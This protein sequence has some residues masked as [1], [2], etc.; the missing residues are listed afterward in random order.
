MC[1]VVGIVTSVGGRVSVGG[2]VLGAACDV[3]A[4]RGPDGAGVWREGHVALG[5]RRLAVVDLSDAGAQP[6]VLRGGGGGADGLARL[7]IAYNGEVYND[8]EIR[9][10]LRAGMESAGER[11]V[12]GCDTETLG[13]AVL[14][15]GAGA[16][17]RVRGMYAFAAYDPSREVLTLA[18][19]PVGIKPLYWARWRVAGRDE[20]GFASEVGALVSLMSAATGSSPR[21]D[22][23]TVSSYLT[24]I[25]TTL[26]DRTLF[27]DVRAV[28]PGQW[29]EIDLRAE[30]LPA[31]VTNSWDG[32]PADGPRAAGDAA[33][34]VRACVEDSVR[35]H[36]R[37]DVPVCA[38]L[39][40]GLDSSITTCIARR[41]KGDLLTFAAGA[42]PGT[43]ARGIDD[44]TA[45]RECAAFFGT[46]HSEA[47]I[48]EPMFHERWAW[49]VDRLGLP[50]STPNE[51]AINQV[52][53]TLR[54]SGCVVTLSGEGADEVFGGY[55]QAL[56]GAA[57]YLE[58][59]GQDPGVH[60]LEHVGWAPLSAKPQLLR[61][62]AWRGLEEDAA[63]VHYYREQFAGL[64]RQ[65]D[66]PLQAHLRWQRKINL[67]GLLQRLDTAMML[68]GVEGRTPFADGEVVRLAESLPM[69]AKFVRAGA[70]EGPIRTK[71]V[72][73]EAF[74]AVLPRVAL[75]RAKA[76]FPLPFGA[77]L[78]SEGG[79]VANLIRGSGL[80]RGLFRDECVELVA[81][82]PGA[83]WRL[84]WPMANLALWERRWW[85]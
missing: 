29:I 67:V 56:D 49:M 78:E 74:R 35:R 14:A 60:E 47:I 4:H 52:A 1:G 73:R 66:D 37:S 59:G 40:G 27:K 18:R 75:E 69:R 42:A 24:T 51:V 26:G 38:L 53:R 76:S 34:I 85:A 6:M 45:A 46:R 44:L 55:D 77:W 64:Q 32:R 17:A 63:L 57:A 82:A 54:A 68:E 25:R 19:D 5:H 33:T 13:R 36:L 15:W 41:E 3:L 9:A 11:F 21:P 48:D 31:R 80:V 50:L 7:V 83:S 79:R 10:Q 70:G 72:L 62:E 2:D 84:A 28:E 65:D 22:L 61:E 39:S 43:D 30:R 81:A 12:S 8:A 20:V 71:L 23:V 58:R 16:A